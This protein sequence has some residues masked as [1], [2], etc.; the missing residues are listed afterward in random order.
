[1]SWVRMDRTPQMRCGTVWVFETESAGV[2]NRRGLRLTMMAGGLVV[3]VLCAPPA[4]AQSRTATLRASATIVGGAGSDMLA[5]EAVALD[6]A[7]WVAS[8]DGA[9]TTRDVWRISGSRSQQLS[10]QVERQSG[11]AGGSPPSVAICELVDDTIN[12]ACLEHRMSSVRVTTA[13]LRP[14][15]RVRVGRMPS[16]GRSAA[17]SAPVLVTIA[18]ITG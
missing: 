12:E 13:G 1:M 17:Q 2:W 15:I 16:T 3:L 6:S 4:A 8:S 5:A 11:V 18:Y 9:A 14:E 7:P 10:I